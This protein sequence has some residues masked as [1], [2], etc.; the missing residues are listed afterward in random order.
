MAYETPEEFRKRI[1]RQKREVIIYGNKYGWT[2]DNGKFY[3][4]S[5]NVNNAVLSEVYSYYFSR[6][7]NT[8]GAPSEKKRI[9]WERGIKRLLA[10]HFLEMY[11]YK[12]NLKD[13]GLQGRQYCMAQLEEMVAM[14]DS[15]EIIKEL[16]GKV[17]KNNDT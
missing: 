11:H 9:E 15:R 4:Y 1:A 7:D 16:Y 17:N 5:V 2:D 8:H 6:I 14:M 3:P 12:L 10:K 13:A